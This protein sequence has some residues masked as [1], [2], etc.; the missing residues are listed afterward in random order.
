VP[1]ANPSSLGTGTDW[2]DLIFRSAPT[3]QHQVSLQGGTDETRFAVSA[4][5]AD[6]QGVIRGT[7]FQRYSLR[8]NVSHDVKSWLTLGTNLNASRMNSSIGFSDAAGTRGAASVMTS[9]L[10]MI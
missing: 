8:A 4:A 5:Y 9:A 10:S 2:Q 6:Q 7:E 1:Y 3:Q